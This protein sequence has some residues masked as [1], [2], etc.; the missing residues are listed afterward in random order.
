M[1]DT[2]KIRYVWGDYITQDKREV[3]AVEGVVR[4]AVY[5]A[6]MGKPEAYAVRCYPRKVLVPGRIKRFDKFTIPKKDI[7][8]S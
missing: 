8:M 5:T 4:C 7:S 3:F 1:D 2:A 6:Y